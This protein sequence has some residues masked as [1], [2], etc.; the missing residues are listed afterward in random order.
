MDLDSDLESRRAAKESN[1]KKLIQAWGEFL[2]VWTY[3]F[4]HVSDVYIPKG[5][6][7]RDGKTNIWHRS[8]LHC[9]KSGYYHVVPTH[10]SLLVNLDVR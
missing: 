9:E 4:G 6:V 1:H 5:Y 8:C 2:C 7:R 10:S 3:P